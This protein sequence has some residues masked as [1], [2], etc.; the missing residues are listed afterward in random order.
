MM[1]VLWF[2]IT[3]VAEGDT[4]EGCW[5]NAQAAL[6]TRFCPDISLSVAYMTEHSARS[7]V[8]GMTC[9]AMK[10]EY[11]GFSGRIGKAVRNPFSEWRAIRPAVLRV[12][13]EV[14][15]DIIC[16]FGTE[17][18]FGLV[19]S[20]VKIPVV[21]HF[22]GHWGSY[23]K[24]WRKVEP[25]NKLFKYYHYNPVKIFKTF[26]RHH[27]EDMST[28]REK[29]VMKR[30]R[31]YLG[32]TNWDKQLVEQYAPDAHYFH[33]EEAIRD[34]IVNARKR[35]QPQAGIMRLVSISSAGE[36][37]GNGFILK[38]AKQLK[39]RG[40]DFVWKV[41]GRKEIFNKF[42]CYTGIK[43]EDVNIELLGLIDADTIVDLLSSST[44]Y[45]HT[46]IIDNSPN[47]L[48]E[49]QL[50]GCPV[51][52]TPIGGIPQLVTE[53]ETGLFVPYDEPTVLADQ[54][55]HLYNDVE[56]QRHLSEQEMSVAHQRHDGAS[57][58]KRLHEIYNEIIDTYT[59]K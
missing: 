37:K 32:R 47:S 40:V 51:V 26:I 16:C 36:L 55:V 58:A 10:P 17:W 50:M 13:E 43:H 42:E 29:V 34:I 22:Q 23:L 44:A 5:I 30:N 33:C 3:P 49:A 25:D 24:E 12:I 14:Q 20:E 28:R 59:Q 41:A 54:L 35:W 2:S 19:S 27:F 46:A 56:I 52:T 4:R 39:Q 9:Y 38:T 57:I 31:F 18:P 48:C 45:V 6:I 53:G 1:K 11:I 8:D 21:I 15:P 7:V